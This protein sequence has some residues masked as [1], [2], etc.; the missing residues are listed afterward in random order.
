MSGEF[1][2]FNLSQRDVSYWGAMEGSVAV[3]SHTLSEVKSL[4]R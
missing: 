2:F 1:T 3:D 4:F